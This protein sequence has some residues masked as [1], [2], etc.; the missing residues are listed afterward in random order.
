MTCLLK[1]MAID[2]I[3][4]P[5]KYKLLHIIESPFLLYS[6]WQILRQRSFFFSFPPPK[7]GPTAEKSIQVSPQKGKRNSRIEG[8]ERRVSA[9][10]KRKGRLLLGSQWHPLSALLKFVEVGHTPWHFVYENPSLVSQKRRERENSM[11]PLTLWGIGEPWRERGG[12][13]KAL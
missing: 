2:P 1:H 10:K 4:M 13:K 12:K 5:C 3:R 7:K 6:I 9:E 8:G 11:M